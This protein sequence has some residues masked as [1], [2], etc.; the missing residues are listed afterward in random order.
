M[1]DHFDGVQIHAGGMSRAPAARPDL[2]SG[3]AD[4]C[5]QSVGCCSPT[6][7]LVRAFM[8]E[9]ARLILGN[10]ECNASLSEEE[11]IAYMER[12]LGAW[13]KVNPAARFR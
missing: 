3:A 2:R 13:R 11:R 5:R 7:H 10:N 8:R 12:A 4:G 6:E 9:A 1:T